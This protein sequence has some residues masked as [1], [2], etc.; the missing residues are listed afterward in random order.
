MEW[1]E[2]KFEELFLSAPILPS[3]AYEKYSIMAKQLGLTVPNK[4]E[5]MI[6]I[7]ND[8]EQTHIKDISNLTTIKINSGNDENK[9][10]VNETVSNHQED[11]FIIQIDSNVKPATM[12]S[13]KTRQVKRGNTMSQFPE[14][15]QY[16]D[17]MLE[18]EMGRMMGFKN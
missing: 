15:N 18:Y 6:T 7:N 5:S 11:K 16:S 1:L 4:Y 9:E 12:E 13:K 17:K 8:Y 14:L 10:I 3:S 2:S